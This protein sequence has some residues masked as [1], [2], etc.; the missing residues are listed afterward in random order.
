M[1]KLVWEE[2]FLK[3]GAPDS[4]IWNIEKGGR[5]FG[6]NEDQFYTDHKQNV[7]IKDG[8]LHLVAYKES[9]EN[10]HYTS[11]KLTTKDKKHFQYGKL[12]VKAKIPRGKGTWPAIW[13]LGENK[14]EAHWPLCGEID[15]MEHVGKREGFIHYSLHSTTYNHHLNNQPTFVLEQ[16]DVTQKFHEYGIIWSEGQVTFTFDEK[17]VATFDKKETDTV[18]EWPFDQPFF[19]ILNLAIGGN[20]GGEIDDSIFPVEFQIDY[21]KLYER[22]D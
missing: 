6:N 19:L 14:K 22:V 16:Q 13:M 7:Y 10:R 20:W 4:S 15:I 21:V 17:E 3:D 5:G 12:V 18:K 2:Q 1:Y 8:V 11:A 9:F